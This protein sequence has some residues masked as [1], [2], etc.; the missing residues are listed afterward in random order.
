MVDILDHLNIN[1]CIGRVFGKYLPVFQP[2]TQAPAPAP[3][4]REQVL[5][6]FPQ[7]LP[8]KYQV[9][10]NEYLEPASVEKSSFMKDFVELLDHTH[11]VTTV[12]EPIKHSH[13][14]R[15]HDSKKKKTKDESLKSTKRDPSAWEYWAKPE[16]KKPGW[17]T[18]PEAAED[19][20]PKQGCGR[21]CKEPEVLTS[22]PEMLETVEAGKKQKRAQNVAKKGKKPKQDVTPNSSEDNS[23]GSELPDNPVEI[24]TRSGRVIKDH[25]TQRTSL[26]F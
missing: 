13:K 26:N 8:N 11:V 12:G 7:V 24:V 22:V 3:S 6:A 25:H 2:K 18:K 21:P 9:L 5:V 15:P 20:V 4:T 19:S 10:A 14:G 16:K 1:T 23:G 17:P